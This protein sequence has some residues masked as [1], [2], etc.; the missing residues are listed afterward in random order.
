MVELEDLAASGGLAL[1]DLQDDA[2]ARSHTKQ[3]RPRRRLLETQVRAARCD[4]FGDID[5]RGVIE[6]EEEV[7]DQERER[8]RRHVAAG[9]RKHRLSCGLDA[10]VR[11][12]RLVLV[13]FVTRAGDRARERR[14]RGL[15]LVWVECVA[16][17]GDRSRERRGHATGEAE[18]AEHAGACGAASGRASFGNLAHQ[19]LP[20]RGT[21]RI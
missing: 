16:R 11:L 1:L 12:C 14:R 6:A 8:A 7:F 18:P 15:V 17:A 9:D 4:A 2:V 21:G 20:K 19:R 3:V 10:Q 5:A 13:Q